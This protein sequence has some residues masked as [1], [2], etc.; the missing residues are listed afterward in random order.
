MEKLRIHI[1]SY[2]KKILRDEF[3]TSKQSV[4]LSLDYVFNSKRAKAI[5][6]R[7]KELLQEEVD[8][9]NTINID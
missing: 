7:A 3:L 4:Q 2:H 8:K 9:I 1:S 5:R 6:E